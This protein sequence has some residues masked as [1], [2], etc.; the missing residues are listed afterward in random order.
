[1]RFKVRTLTSS[2]SPVCESDNIRPAILFVEKISVGQT[3]QRRS[4]SICASCISRRG[5]YL[6]GVEPNMVLSDEPADIE[7]EIKRQEE[8]S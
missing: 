7:A 3:G 6:C 2:D 5:L 4:Q 8:G 1:M